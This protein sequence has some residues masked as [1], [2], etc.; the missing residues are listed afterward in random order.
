MLVLNEN[1]NSPKYVLTVLEVANK[2]RQLGRCSRCEKYERK[3]KK[4]MDEG[5]L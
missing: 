5:K 4:L 2:F 1:S 3:C